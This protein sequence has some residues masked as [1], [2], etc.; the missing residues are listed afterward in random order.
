MEIARISNTKE[1]KGA[2]I[3][4]KT[5]D[6]YNMVHMV[7][8]SQ[9]VLALRV[10]EQIIRSFFT[11]EFLVRLVCCPHKSK[12]LRHLSEK[13]NQGPV[14]LTPVDMVLSPVETLF[15]MVSGQDW[16]IMVRSTAH[17]TPSN[18]HNIVD[19]VIICLMWLRWL[20]EFSISQHPED[21][22]Y[23]E[24][25]YLSARASIRELFLLTVVMGSAVL[26]FGTLMFLVEAL[27]GSMG[28]TATF[29]SVL[30]A[31]WWAVITMT[32][33]GYGDYYPTTPAG[34]VVGTICALTGL[35]LVAMPIAIIASNFSDFYDNMTSRDQYMRRQALAKKVLCCTSGGCK[36]HGGVETSDS[37][38]AGS[39]ELVG[40]EGKSG[41][42][43]I[44]S[45]L[46]IL[47][48]D[49]WTQPDVKAK[50]TENAGLKSEQKK[51]ND[52]L[53]DNNNI[54]LILDDIDQEIDDSKPTVK[55]T[56]ATTSHSS[57][58]QGKNRTS[59]RGANV[60]ASK[61]MQSKHKVHPIA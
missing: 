8:F 11:I 58:Q 14:S 13:E 15:V 53:Q 51:G 25:M 1:G 39:G 33:V 2:A 17:Q 5:N 49:M 54:D 23:K 59:R 50:K 12:F 44:S 29:D 26:L 56:R 9:P 10:L 36:T 21:Y 34:Y 43:T 20:M 52:K 57:L 30:R 45:E 6:S 35:L 41:P 46:D 60:N 32:T 42:F 28:E 19:M 38:G 16:T 22:N 3:K 61:E 24:V 31:M 40:K 47:S 48:T 37:D 4:W 27:H 7:A 55:E 18:G